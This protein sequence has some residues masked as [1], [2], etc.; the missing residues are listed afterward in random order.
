M[1]N[2]RL[3]H[4][5]NLR[6]QYH[7]WVDHILSVARMAGEKARKLGFPPFI[8]DLIMLVAYL[9]DL[10]KLD[11]KNYWALQDG[12]LSRLPLNHCDAGVC[13]LLKKGFVYPAF[14]VGHH[15][16]RMQNLGDLKDACLK[17]QKKDWKDY[18]CRDDN[19]E[20]VQYTNSQLEY[21]V[22]LLQQE[23]VDFNIEKYG[24]LNDQEAKKK[25][26]ETISALDMRFLL[27]CLSSSD[28][29]DTAKHF[30]L[31]IFDN[32][33]P[34]LPEERLSHLLSCIEQMNQN[35][36]SNPRKEMRKKLCDYVSKFEI[37]GDCLSLCSPVGSG[38]TF[39]GLI[40]ALRMSKKNNKDRIFFISPRINILDQVADNIKKFLVLEGENP[41]DVVILHH[42]R[43]KKTNA[44]VKFM[45]THYD[46][47]IIVTSYV[48]FMETLAS[49]S[50]A[51]LAK[52]PS[53]NNSVIICDEFHESVPIDLQPITMTWLHHLN[54]RYNCNLIFMSGTMT[55]TW[56]NSEINL[57][58]LEVQ[59]ILSDEL[60]QEFIS[61]E[62][63][64][65]IYD[66]INRPFRSFDSLIERIVEEDKGPYLVIFNTIRAAAF[67]AYTCKQK[68]IEAYN[69]SNAFAPC[70]LQAIY[71]KIRERL[72]SGE[73]N[74]VV[75]ATQI[76]TTGIEFSSL[77]TFRTGFGERSSLMSFMQQG[78]RI[79]RHGEY[80]EPCCHYDFVLDYNS[81]GI[82]QGYSIFQN[83]NMVDDI[84]DTSF[85][86]D[87]ENI[88][89]KVNNDTTESVAN[90]WMNKVVERN[91]S[92]N[93]NWRQY[94]DSLIKAEQK[95]NFETIREGYKVIQDDTIKVIINHDVAEEIIK[96]GQKYG[97][98]SSTLENVSITVYRNNMAKRKWP[99]SERFFGDND[100]DKIYVW[101]GAYD[102]H[103]LGYMA[104]FIPS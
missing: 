15:H 58:G 101:D 93:K 77:K 50:P 62:K 104:E 40:T 5:K 103:L 38:K 59:S 33:T 32:N 85:L 1:K 42:S 83:S 30:N 12:N 48:Q 9:H 7:L 17:M 24:Y 75:C 53:L 72:E 92:R 80:Q 36:I 60:K 35:T 41:D 2:K 57:S 64:R 16:R 25:I 44:Q 3:A 19:P 4:S 49:N 68:G 11:D 61:L 65:V 37:P 76:A 34:L 23:L 55:E 27:G 13:Y 79:N 99:I 66:T 78:G 97:V 28:Y 71:D 70:D 63:N 88:L 67:A 87:R 46:A 8:V 95:L 26:I 54:S 69:M 74:F 29:K 31:D 20:V 47:R 56:K 84:R 21:Y 14:L 98:R 51:K 10:G 18:F 86:I 100:E 96:K 43:N 90:I 22:N 6:G 102:P 81:P 89:E 82:S 45:T 73:K 39:A 91:N 94:S 52:I